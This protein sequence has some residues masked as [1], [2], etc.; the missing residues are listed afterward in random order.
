MWGK[1]YIRRKRKYFLIIFQL[2]SSLG[3]WLKKKTDEI[4]S[5]NAYKCYPL[6]VYLNSSN[7]K[8]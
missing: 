1:K 5:I 4:V 8:F 6:N 3:Y 2:I 7:L